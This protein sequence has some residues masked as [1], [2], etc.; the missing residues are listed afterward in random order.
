MNY[1]RYSSMRYDPFDSTALFRGSGLDRKL[2]GEYTN[3][4]MVNS[5]RDLDLT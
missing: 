5:G 1:R 3:E 4:V 2:S